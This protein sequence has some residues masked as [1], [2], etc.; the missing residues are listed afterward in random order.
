M[1]A[2]LR[3]L[4]GSAEDDIWAVGTAGTALHWD[5]TRWSPVGEPATFSLNDVWGRSPSDVWAVGSGGTILHYDGAAWQP[6]F[7]GT[8]QALH[9]VWG[10]GERLWVVGESG[11]ILIKELP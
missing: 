3:G 2:D 7:S 9:G 8:L 11:S 5:G 6:E 1:N 10:D 4:W